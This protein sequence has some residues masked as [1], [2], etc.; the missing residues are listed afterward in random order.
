M[1]ASCLCVQNKIKTMTKTMM[2]NADH[3]MQLVSF[4]RQIK[5]KSDRITNYFLVF[6]LTFGFILSF[7]YNT[8]MVAIGVG[9]ISVLAYYST[10]RM[11]PDSNLYQYV[12]SAVVGIFMAQ[13]IYQMH[14]MFEMHFM[15]FIGSAMLITYQNWKLQIPLVLV[16]VLHHAVFGYLQYIGFEKIYFTQLEYMD[17]RTFVIHV[18]LAAVIFFICGLWSYHFQKYSERNIA[19]SVEIGR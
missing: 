17:M 10:K 6:Y 19:Q 11:L 18:M 8:W 9:G 2:Q 1:V 16:V 7:F 3:E 4:D 12:L 13:Y 5:Y 15:A 14:G